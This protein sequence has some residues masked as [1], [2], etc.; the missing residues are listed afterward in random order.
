VQG[1][2]TAGG[3]AGLSGAERRALLMGWACGMALVVFVIAVNVITRAVGQSERLAKVV[4][5]E[6][7]SA[8]TMAVALLVAAALALWIRRRRPP[9]W[10]MVAACVLGFVPYLAVHVGGFVGIRALAEPAVIRHPYR[11]TPLAPQLVYEG[12]KDT[13]GYVISLAGFWLFLR[14][15]GVSAPS[16]RPMAPATFDIRDGARLVRTPVAG[17]VAVRS[18]ANYAEFI[19][20]D[21]RRPLMRTSL[22]ALEARLAAHG[23]VRTHR[24]WLVNATQVRGLRPEGSGDY[25]IELDGLEAPLSRRYRAALEALRR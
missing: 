2:V 8:L 19:L 5:E 16:N 3:R 10:L 13:L 17:I 24:S 7:S 21:G 22:G 14:W 6:G 23:F 25:A 11:F 20:S 4:L 1:G 9:T 18:A 15:F 12:A